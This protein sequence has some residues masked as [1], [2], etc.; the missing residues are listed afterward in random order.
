[1]CIRDRTE[2]PADVQPSPVL[3]QIGGAWPLDGRQVGVVVGE[4]VDEKELDALVQGIHG[5]GMVPLVIAP[6]GGPVAG[7]IVAQRTY[8]TA[9]SIELDAVVVASPAAPAA[10]AAPSLDQ[11]AGAADSEAVDPRVVKVLQEMWRHSK[12]I[13]A[14]EPAE[15]VLAAAQVSGKGVESAADGASA[16]SRLTE[17]LPAHRVWERFPTTGPVSYTHLTLPTT[18]Y[19]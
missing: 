19:V 14:L 3:S 18:P 17:L 10:D 15:A 8:L 13:L 4:S 11:K 16:V 7:E 12:A 5:A 6:K 1:M 9:A 2:T